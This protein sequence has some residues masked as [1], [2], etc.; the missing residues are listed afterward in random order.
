MDELFWTLQP[1]VDAADDCT[2]FVRVNSVEALGNTV[3]FGWSCLFR[4]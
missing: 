1:D 3:D 2:A 4:G